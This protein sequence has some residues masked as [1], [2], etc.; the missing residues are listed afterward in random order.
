MAS[1]NESGLVF[2]SS[3]EIADESQIIR[4]VN[5]TFLDVTLIGDTEILPAQGAG[6]RIRILAMYVRSAAAVSVR[7]K[8]AGNN[9]I[10]ASFSLGI[11]DDILYPYCK[12]G[13]FQTNANEAFNINQSL[14]VATG[15]QVVWI[16]V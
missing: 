15:I 14:A 8:S 16:V 5:R 2:E 11:N 7:F 6:N 9:N 1:T 12:H 3:R 13:W 10:S 4:T